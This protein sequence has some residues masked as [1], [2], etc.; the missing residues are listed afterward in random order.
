MEHA[1]FKPN[2]FIETHIIPPFTSAP[3]V[4][5]T[6]AEVEGDLQAM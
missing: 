5:G 1:P 6:G 3:V 2:D 4:G